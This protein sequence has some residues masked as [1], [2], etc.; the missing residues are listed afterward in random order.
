MSEYSFGYNEGEL[1]EPTQPESDNSTI[2]ALRARAEADSKALEELRE[3]VQTLQKETHQ[4]KVAD[5]LKAKGYAPTAAGLYT[6]T[7]DKLDDWLGTH[8][9]ALAKVSVEGQ[10]Q[11]GEQTPTGPPASTVPA[12]G[13]E[14]MRLMQ[15]AGTSGAAAPQGSEA[16]LVNRLKQAGPDEYAQIMAANGSRFDWS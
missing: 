13:Q 15:E 12:D 2:K 5:A 14:Q 10:G 4:V 11:D 1:N 3:Q 7:P 9:A 8:G 16:E 6:G